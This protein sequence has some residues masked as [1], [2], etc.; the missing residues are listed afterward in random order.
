MSETTRAAALTEAADIARGIADRFA[1]TANTSTSLE[2]KHW[3]AMSAG[4]RAVS[5]KLTE[6]ADA[7]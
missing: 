2:R 4:A 3:I 6:L 5:L 1:Q 7:G